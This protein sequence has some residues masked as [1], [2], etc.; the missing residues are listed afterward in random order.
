[1]D[2]SQTSTESPSPLLF[3]GGS[4]VILPRDAALATRGWRE[5]G[6]KVERPRPVWMALSTAEDALKT[7]K[8]TPTGCKVTWVNAPGREAAMLDT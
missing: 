4:Q 8:S 2:K 5:Q 7:W 6:S 3:F 1:M